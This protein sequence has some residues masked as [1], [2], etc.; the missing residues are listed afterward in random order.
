MIRCVIIDDEPLAVKLL[1]SYI[2]KL[3]EVQLVSSHTNPMDGLKALK[4]NTVDLLFLDIQMP[5]IT[6]VQMARLIPD[7]TQI[8][9]T[10]AYPEYAVEGFELKA[11][12]Y[13]VKPIS[14]DRFIKAVGR[15]EPG[16]SPSSSHPAL[17][18][19]HIFVKTEYRRLKI[20]L[21]DIL[22]LMGM[23]DY[24]QIVMKG[25]KV[26]TLEKI[27]SFESRLPQDRFIRVHKSYLISINKIE[28]LEKNRIKISNELI[29]IGKTYE[30][31]V[32][33]MIGS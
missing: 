13:L 19:N 18:L 31:H 5:E 3:D 14:L 4:E 27:R 17:A 21:D 33:K 11:L 28:Y 23:G 29:P 12:D 20:D 8:I 6:G 32:K 16:G 22:Y 10:T 7:K 1:E 25:K 24:C 9:F 15:C 26:M 2:S 30:E